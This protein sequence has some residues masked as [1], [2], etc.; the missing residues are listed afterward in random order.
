VDERSWDGCSIAGLLL[1][2]GDSDYVVRTSTTVPVYVVNY[3]PVDL[4]GVLRRV[5]RAG[6]GRADRRSADRWADPERP[7]TGECLHILTGHTAPLG[8][9]LLAPDDSWLATAGDDG[10]VQIWDP[11]TGTPLRTLSAHSGPVSELAAGPD[12]AWLASAGT[13]GTVGIWDPATG[14]RHHT[15]WEHPGP[16]A[17]VAVA[18]DGSWL[19]SAGSDGTVRV[20]DPATG[21]NRSA[22]RLDDEPWRAVAVAPDLVVL[23]GSHGPHFLRLS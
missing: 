22:L 14:Q 9:L 7:A 2:D 17:A 23:A 18:P 16:V 6:H 11:G 3:D 4:R 5:R 21:V 19:V 20:W 10:T 8:T 1:L 13:D 15:L 12:G